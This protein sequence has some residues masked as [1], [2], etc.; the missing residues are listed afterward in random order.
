VNSALA[1]RLPLEKAKVIGPPNAG[2]GAS[3]IATTNKVRDIRVSVPLDR[4][5]ASALNKRTRGIDALTTF[6][7]FPH[8]QA[9]WLVIGV[10]LL[11][12]GL[13][14]LIAV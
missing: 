11:K 4:A 1:A 14:Q 2:N 6:I 10:S 13:S 12:I 5:K 9:A 7:E 8:K 3:A